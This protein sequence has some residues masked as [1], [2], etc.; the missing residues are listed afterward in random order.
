MTLK[1]FALSLVRRILGRFD[2]HIA[3]LSSFQQLVRAEEEEGIAARKLAIL[4]ATNEAAANF[5][6]LVTDSRAQLQQEAF[7]LAVTGFKQGGYFV[8]FGAADGVG[9]SNTFVLERDFGWRGILAEPARGWHEALKRNR[10]LAAIVTDCVWSKSGEHLVFRETTVRELSTLNS[11]IGGDRHSRVRARGVDYGVSTISLLDMLR[12]HNAPVFI[13]YLSIDT[14]GSE[15]EILSA[16]D[17]SRH[18]FGVI[19]VEHNFTAAR[20]RICDLLTGAGYVRRLE[21]CSKY[22]DWYVHSSMAG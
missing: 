17:F 2:L 14:E 13:D 1:Q 16:F 10:P 5:V 11:Q 8:E 20:E 19:T 4:Q 6:A 7:V 3:R 21:Q 22:D 9:L 15:Y 12:Q 18:Q